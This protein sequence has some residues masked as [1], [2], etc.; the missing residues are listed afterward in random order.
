LNLVKRSKSVAA[1]I[2][3]C[4]PFPRPTEAV[5]AY[6]EG[7]DSRAVAGLAGKTLG[8]Q[9]RPRPRR[10]QGCR[11]NHFRRSAAPFRESSLQIQE[12]QNEPSRIERPDP[13][14]QFALI[15]GLAAY[16]VDARQIL[17]PES[18]QGSIGPALVTVSHAYPDY[19]NHPLFTKRMA[20]F[21]AALL[22]NPAEFVFPRLWSTKGETL[23]EFTALQKARRG[24]RRDLAG[25]MCAGAHSITNI[26]SAA[27]ARPVC[28]AA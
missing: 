9:T 26:Y 27:Y 12:D 13:G 19:R 5:I 20:R 15:S 1:P 17:V 22:K 28:C 2:Q 3:E 23:R 4:L 10:L 21:L 25:E 14:L 7:M 24:K 18:G 8:G 11:Q 6:S 16:L